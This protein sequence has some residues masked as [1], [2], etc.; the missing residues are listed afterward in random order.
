MEAYGGRWNVDPYQFWFRLGVPSV[1]KFL[2]P[3]A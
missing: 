1:L 3:K 2:N